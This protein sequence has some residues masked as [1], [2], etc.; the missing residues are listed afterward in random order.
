MHLNCWQSLWVILASGFDR[1]NCI[2][3]LVCFLK[4]GGAPLVLPHQF[5]LF[6]TA[7][8]LAV[9]NKNKLQGGMKQ[10]KVKLS[11]SFD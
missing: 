6:Q 10:K 9:W 3:L 4:K 1:V 5:V 8:V 2:L 11:R 7:E